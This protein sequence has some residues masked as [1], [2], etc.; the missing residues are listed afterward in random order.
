MWVTKKKQ[1]THTL[2]TMLSPPLSLSLVK[3]L[4][5]NGKCCRH[6]QRHFYVAFKIG[7]L[8]FVLLFLSLS[9]TLVLSFSAANK[10]F[11][12]SA[13]ESKSLPFFFGRKLF[14][15]TLN[16]QLSMGIDSLSCGSFTQLFCF[17]TASHHFEKLDF[18]PV[19]EQGTDLAGGCL[20]FYWYVYSSIR[21]SHA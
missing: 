14:N 11:T 7:C 10:K 8:C 1:H 15:S 19:W 17:H 13:V 9:L 12:A 4:N 21:R 6:Y 2:I 5:E 3:Y 16:S 20:P 18:C